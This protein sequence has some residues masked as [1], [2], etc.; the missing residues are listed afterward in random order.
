MYILILNLQGY[1][2][3]TNGIYGYSWDMMVHTWDIQS[4]VVKVVD[5]ENNN[6]FFADP[7][8]LTPND[9]WFKH[10]DMVQQYAMCLKN[11]IAKESRKLLKNLG[12]PSQNISIYIDIWCSLNGR[13]VQRMFNPKSDLLEVS[14]SF[15]QEIPFLMPVIDNASEWR[16]VLDQIRKHVH[17]WNQHSDVIFFA[18]FPGLCCLIY[19]S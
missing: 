15:Y 18:D 3:W 19:I 5:H 4:V 16:S 9:R 7:Y 2:N 12:T 8:V 6:E 14:W 1:N 17:G 13:F 10:G 11:N